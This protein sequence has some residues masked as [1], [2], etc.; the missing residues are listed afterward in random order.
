MRDKL[1]LRR[2]QTNS[3]QVPAIVT[4][5]ATDHLHFRL[6]ALQHMFTSPRCYF[7]LATPFFLTF[8]PKLQSITYFPLYKPIQT[9]YYRYRTDP[10]RASAAPTAPAHRAGDV[11]VFHTK[12]QTNRMENGSVY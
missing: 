9:H 12:S 3:N 7:V 11:N 10:T 1:P 4:N 5:T 6:I 2:W 8:D